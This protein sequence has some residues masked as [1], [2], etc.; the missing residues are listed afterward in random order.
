MNKDLLR[1]HGTLKYDDLIPAFSGALGKLN[2]AE[3]F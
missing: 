2:P 3:D 1:I